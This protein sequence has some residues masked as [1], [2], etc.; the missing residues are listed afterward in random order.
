MQRVGQYVYR[1]FFP[2]HELAVVP[3]VFR[4]IDGHIRLSC[5]LG[6]QPGAAPAAPPRAT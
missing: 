4:C 6:G 3:D 2:G 1:G 5:V